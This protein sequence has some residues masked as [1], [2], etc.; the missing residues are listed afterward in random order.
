MDAEKLEASHSNLSIFNQVTLHIYIYTYIYVCLFIYGLIY[1]LVCIYICVHMSA[2][3][4]FLI[5]HLHSQG[6]TIKLLETIILNSLY[7]SLGFRRFGMFQ[8][9]GF[10]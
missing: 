8:D 7:G 2:Y 10:G 1:Y 9:F 6:H 3:V 5:G 4:E